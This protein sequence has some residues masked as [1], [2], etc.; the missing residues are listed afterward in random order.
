MRK[1]AIVTMALAIALAVPVITPA[2]EAPQAKATA[3][4]EDKE[5]TF[6]GIPWG[7]SLEEVEN[8][9]FL[10]KYTDYEYN[11]D[12]HAILINDENLTVAQKSTSAAM[13][14]GN[15]GLYQVAYMLSEKHSNLNSYVEDFN[16]V[17]DALTK[18]YGEPDDTED[19]WKDD[20]YK[21]DPSDYGMA[22]GAG[23]VKFIRRWYGNDSSLTI[24]CIGDN[25]EITNVICYNSLSLQPE[26][27]EDDGL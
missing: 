27:T 13:Y 14:F 15:S 10:K 11:K 25:F 17:L 7:S 5:Y 23:H 2:A 21:D 6:R 22:V 26:E 4:S 20:L 12:Y 18:K 3:E 24:G 9:D 16:D 1:H 19:D 8:S